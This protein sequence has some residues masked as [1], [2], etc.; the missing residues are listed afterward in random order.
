M[1]IPVFLRKRGDGARGV[2]GLTLS[3][4]QQSPSTMA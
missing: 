3:G 2:L 1:R 4:V